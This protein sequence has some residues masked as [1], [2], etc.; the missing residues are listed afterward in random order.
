MKSLMLAS[1]VLS[2]MTGAAFAQSAA[3]PDLRICTG[4][5]TGRY[6]QT[7]RELGAQLKNQIN[8]IPVVTNGSVDNLT[9]LSTGQCD[10]A[11]IQSDAYGF[12]QQRY[13]TAQLDF[14]RVATLYPEYVHMVCNKSVEIEAVGDVRKN[15]NI[16]VL[17]G[18]NGSGT[19]VTWETWTKQDE[20]YAKVKTKPIGGIEALAM[21]MDG[22]EA[23]CA[24]FVAGLKSA[25]MME[26]DGFA[27]GTVGLVKVDD[28]WFDDVKDPK[29]QG[30]YNMS[31]I[32]ANT[33]PNLQTSGWFGGDKTP[34][35][36]LDAVLVANTAWTEA[37]PK[38]YAELIKKSL[39]WAKAN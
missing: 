33:Y 9:M 36:T 19:Q 16:T 24:L 18:P 14:K 27:D 34:T 28:G 30:V 29:G 39:A 5:D 1:A 20:S 26:Y 6:F 37:N 15:E 25:T 13:P 22:S 32:P 10:A 3:I 23:Q 38:A 17:T 21:I 2:L 4:L 35:I 11:L 12:H 7:A 31:E 8:V